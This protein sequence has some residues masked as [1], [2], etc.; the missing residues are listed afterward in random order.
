[1]KNRDGFSLLEILVALVIFSIAVGGMMVGLG[2]HLKDVS[3]TED[4][5]RA[6]R[7]ASREMNMLRRLSYFPE[8]EFEGEEDRFAWFAMVEETDMDD[9]PGMDSTEESSR[10]AYNPCLMSVRVE[11]AEVD[12]G[13]RTKNVSLQ[14]YELFRRR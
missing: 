8:E 2:Y 7:I 13:E 10:N 12:G 5:A 4:H 6:V 3:F 11:W 14:G 9:M 1:V